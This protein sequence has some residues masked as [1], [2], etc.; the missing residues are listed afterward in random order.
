MCVYLC[1]C[2]CVCVCACV[3]V[4]VFAYM[5]MFPFSSMVWGTAVVCMVNTL[6]SII[7]GLI[8]FI[9]TIMGGGVANCSGTP[10]DDYY[11][12]SQSGT[13]SSQNKVRTCLSALQRQ[14]VCLHY[15]V[16][17]SVCLSVYLHHT[18]CFSVCLSVC[19]SVC[20][21]LAVCLIVCLSV[22][23]SVC[24]LSVCLPYSVYLSA[25][26]YL[27]ISLSALQYLSVWLSICL[28]V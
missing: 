9:I 24:C 5:R 23:L 21:T 25:R 28:S 27:S 22:C 4:C 1:V 12:S 15:T 16:C 6:L 18:G 3:Y 14:S 19:L 8:G 2:V 7:L 26:Q 20:T 11:T 13:P 17:L 10:P